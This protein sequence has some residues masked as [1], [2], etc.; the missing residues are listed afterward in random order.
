MTLIAPGFAVWIKNPA[1]GRK[2]HLY[3]VI[4]GPVGDEGRILL[5]NMTTKREGSDLS[6]V[7]SPGDHPCVKHESVV[8]YGRALYTTV[9]SLEMQ[10][11]KLPDLFKPDVPASPELLRRLR[12]GAL[13][14]PHLEPM[15]KQLVKAELQGL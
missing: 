12:E 2:P 8:E 7:L 10:M 13:R 14:S 5:V 6:C 4:A 11:R 1:Q 3:F 9:A 15:Y